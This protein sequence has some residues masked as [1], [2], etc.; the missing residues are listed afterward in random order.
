MSL[1]PGASNLES[2]LREGIEEYRRKSASPLPENLSLILHPIA[3][4]FSLTGPE[5]SGNPIALEEKRAE[6]FLHVRPELLRSA[7]ERAIKGWLHHVLGHYQL[8]NQK[9]FSPFNFSRQILPLFPV[10]GSAV[11]LVR[12]IVE[13]LKK[14]LEAF[15]TIRWIAAS[16]LGEQQVALFSYR[17]KTMEE[18]LEPYQ[19]AILHPWIRASCLS[20][21]LQ[22]FLAITGLQGQDSSAARALKLQWWRRHAQL[23][24]EDQALLEEMALVPL[25]GGARPFPALLAELFQLLRSSLLS[26]P[27][28]KTTTETWH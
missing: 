8:T 16:G 2:C 13:R 20:G 25:E 24:R 11:N 22:H 7:P 10:T 1:E 23:L 6:L 9:A 28:E 3:A 19:L 4:G 21:F 18:D 12:Q 26:A 14:G 15:L 27:A 17:L 5:H